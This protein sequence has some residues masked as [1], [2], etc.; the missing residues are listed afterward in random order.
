M[1]NL[2][3]RFLVRFIV[4]FGGVALFSSFLPQKETDGLVRFILDV[5]ISVITWA[6]FVWLLSLLGVPSTILLLL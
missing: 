4:M 6:I 1:L 3:I 5:V 2:F